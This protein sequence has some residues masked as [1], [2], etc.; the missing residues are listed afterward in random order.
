M[1][2]ALVL[3]WRVGAAVLAA[4]AVV[5]QLSNRTRITPYTLVESAAI[6]QS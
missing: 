5:Y 1:Q 3:Q 4:C 2:P 6:V